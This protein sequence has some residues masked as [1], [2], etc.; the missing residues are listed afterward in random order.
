M[1]EFDHARRTGKQRTEDDIINSLETE[2]QCKLSQNLEQSDFSEISNLL[3]NKKN[4]EESADDFLD[5]NEQ[6]MDMPFSAKDAKEILKD[7]G[8][9]AKLQGRSGNV[10]IPQI[11]KEQQRTIARLMKQM[12]DPVSTAQK[13]RAKISEKKV[14]KVK[15]SQQKKRLK[16][17]MKKINNLDTEF[18]GE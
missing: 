7:I 6:L 15:Q 17:R 2:L 14:N 9:T 12:H 8:F 18:T 4:P 11:L 5:S 13:A 1:A 3:S 16:R 10:S